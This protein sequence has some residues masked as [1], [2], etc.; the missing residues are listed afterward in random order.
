MSERLAA[1]IYRWRRLLTAII[2]AGAAASIPSVNITHID[3][4][5][6]AWFS[7]TDPVYVDYE[8]FRSEFGGTRSLI[9]AIQ[10]D[11]PERLFS[12]ATIAF[13]ERITGDIER[14]DTVQRV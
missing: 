10:A 3:N 7:R 1:F 14:V 13:I 6:T 9:I 4:D 2:F 8:R 11:S 5:I 12:A